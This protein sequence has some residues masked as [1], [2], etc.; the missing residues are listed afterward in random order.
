MEHKNWVCVKCRNKSFE[1]GEM[2]VSGGFW[3]KL[4]DV[5]NNKYTAV[6]CNRCSYTEFYKGSSSS[7]GNVFDFLAG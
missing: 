2:R 3:S 1:I 5:Q 4:F 7:I 6:T